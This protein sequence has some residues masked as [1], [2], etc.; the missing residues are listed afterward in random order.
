MT[1]QRAA[2]TADQGRVALAQRRAGHGPAQ[3]DQVY[4]SVEDPADPVAAD[5]VDPAAPDEAAV[6]DQADEGGEP[7]PSSEP[8]TEP[9]NE[10]TTEQHAG[11]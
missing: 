10:P 3:P 6:T 2:N 4:D 7:E 9:T 11:V 5:E 8:N 1:L